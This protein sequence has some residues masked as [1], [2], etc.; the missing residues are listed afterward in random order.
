MKIGE[1]ELLEKRVG[2]GEEIFRFSRKA[3]QY[4][5]TNGYVL[6]FAPAGIKNFCKAAGSLP[7]VHAQECIIGPAL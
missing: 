3:R 1:I 6:Y 4:I 5:Y 7:H 2:L